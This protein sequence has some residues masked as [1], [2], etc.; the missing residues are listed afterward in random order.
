M[1]WWDID[2]ENVTGDGPADV[3]RAALDEIAAGRD[4]QGRPRPTLAEVLGGFAR[5]LRAF[6][7]G[8]G[9]G[10][11]RRLD[12]HLMSAHEPVPG[13]ED[14]ADDQTVEAFGRALAQVEGQYVERWG[15]KPRRIELLKALTF[16]LGY[17]PDRFLSDAGGI[18]ILQIVAR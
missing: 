6:E 18:S 3:M 11:F 17:R 2:A 12:A 9:A 7:R 5:A 4:G 14:A 15:R 16:V 8:P 1:S 10:D 13:A